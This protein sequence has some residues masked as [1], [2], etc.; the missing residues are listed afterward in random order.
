MRLNSL[1]CVHYVFACPTPRGSHPL[2]D[3]PVFNSIVGVV[4]LFLCEKS[5]HLS[6]PYLTSKLVEV[7]QVPLLPVWHS[8]APIIPCAPIPLHFLHS[9]HTWPA[10]AIPHLLNCT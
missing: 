8:L 2:L 1:S 3:D 10:L 4:L 9:S 5:G 6:N 7:L